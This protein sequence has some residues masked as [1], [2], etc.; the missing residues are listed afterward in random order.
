L[1]RTLSVSKSHPAVEKVDEEV[2]GG[3]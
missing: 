2:T 3:E 1:E